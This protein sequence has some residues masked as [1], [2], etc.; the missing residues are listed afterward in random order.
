MNN[1][2]YFPQI[3]ILK[4]L[5][6]LSVLLLHSLERDELLSSF[7]IFHIWQAVPIFLVLMGFN[8]GMSTNGKHFQLT[9]LYDRSYFFKKGSRIVTPILI[10][11]VASLI[12]GGIWYV[13]TGEDPFI[14]KGYTAIGMLP[15]PGKGN[16]FVTLVLQ[17]ILLLPVIGYGLYYKPWLSATILVIAEISFLIISKNIAFF[18]EERYLY[19]AAFLR[20][21]SAVALGYGLVHLV[22]YKNGFGLLLLV[23]GAVISALYLYFDIYT[24][25][26]VQYIRPEWE[27][28]NFMAFPYAALF[29]YVGFKLFPA[30]INNVFVQVLVEIGKASFHIFLV[31]VIY[32][33]LA[34]PEWPL[35]LNLLTCT[36][37]GYIFYQ[38]ETP[39]ANATVL[40]WKKKK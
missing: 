8:L 21:L 3:D 31:Q 22:K 7:S 26:D 37:I 29:V 36:S 1:K 4:G 11:Y 20:Y 32:F 25:F 16:Y 33:G 2:Q 35:W 14:F 28:Q 30:T 18:V 27:A 23:T 40:L 6:I 12:T 10:A 9:E 39:I 5:A 34:E 19:D 17:S 13:A 38:Y 15:V 24:D